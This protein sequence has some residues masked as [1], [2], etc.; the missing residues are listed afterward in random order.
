[1]EEKRLNPQHCFC[2]LHIDI[3]KKKA[4]NENDLVACPALWTQDNK[5]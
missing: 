2:I 3:W 1:M 4:T 5:K